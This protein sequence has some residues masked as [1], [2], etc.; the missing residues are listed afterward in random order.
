MKI[1]ASKIVGEL[2]GDP[3]NRRQ[4]A[5]ALKPL[6]ASDFAGRLAEASD[7]AA[8]VKV[9]PL[10]AFRPLTPMEMVPGVKGPV[11]ALA[12]LDIDGRASLRGAAKRGGPEV[13]A[14][15]PLAEGDLEYRHASSRAPKTE[16]EKVVEQAR[17]W[18]AQTFYGAM[19]KQMRESPFKSEVFSGGRGGQAFSSMLDQH[20]ADHMSRSAGSKLV[21]V[22]ARKLEA[23]AGYAKQAVPKTPSSS[24]SPNQM[25]M[26]VAPSLR[27]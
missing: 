12:P 14:L 11:K 18:V 21:N 20:L 15:A 10:G 27:A 5:G 23:R 17:K 9:Q 1:A 4:G 2:S 19:L 6:A 3:V 22:I 13:G 24:E 8:G 7:D 26:H 25:R 16:H